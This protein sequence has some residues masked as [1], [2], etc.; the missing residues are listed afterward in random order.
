MPYSSLN[1]FEMKAVQNK[2]ILCDPLTGR[3]HSTCKQQHPGHLCNLIFLFGWCILFVRLVVVN[4]HTSNCSWCSK[5]DDDWLWG[6]EC[7]C[8]KSISSFLWKMGSILQTNYICL[9]LCIPK[10]Y[11]EVVIFTFSTKIKKPSKEVISVFA[12]IQ[13]LL[14]LL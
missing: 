2:N 12:T 13:C 9:V 10:Y 14:S 5:S 1:K 3:R 7:T 6:L 11:H 4:T 8:R